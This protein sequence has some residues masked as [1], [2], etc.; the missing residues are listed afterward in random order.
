[1]GI[2]TYAITIRP[3][4]A[5]GTP[6]KGD[7]LFGQFCWQAA[8]DP[9]LLRHGL[10]HWIERYAEQPFVVFSSAWPVIVEEGKTLYAL[11]RPDLPPSLL[12]D[13]EGVTSC[14]ERLR[15][16]KANKARRWFLVPDSMTA[17]LSW[18]NLVDDKTLYER[19]LATFTEEERF[20]LRRNRLK[21]PVAICQQQHNTI[22]R[23]TMTTGKGMF[24]PFVMDNIWYLPGMELAVFAALD[25]EAVAIEKVEQALERIGAYGFGRD[26]STGLGRFTVVDTAEIAWPQWRPG[27]GLLALGPWVPEPG[28]Y[29]DLFCRPFTRFGRHGAQLLASNRP[30]KN[31]VV[32]ADEGSVA[33]SDGPRGPVIGKAVN[34]ISKAME[35][36]VAQG[37]TLALPV[38]VPA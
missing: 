2:T 30:F 28:R 9:G 15:A 19:L 16:R 24:A 12:G 36:C 29:Q 11:P 26:A 14:A 25:E 10:D 23:A 4:S 6:L 7:T 18:D 33:V 35:Q 38:G 20:L 27:C 37:Y 21:A 31:P 17:E 1:M 22:N 8:E 32:M 5:F 3:E 34:N 13:P